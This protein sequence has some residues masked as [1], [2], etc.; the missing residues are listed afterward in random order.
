MS[1]RTQRP[2]LE[3][4]SDSF[5]DV[6]CNI[7][8]ILIILIV[9]VGVRLQRQPLAREAAAP[10]QQQQQLAEEAMR[11]SEHDEAVQRSRATRQELVQQQGHLNSDEKRLTTD[12]EAALQQNGMLDQQLAE[13]RGRIDAQ[14][15]ELAGKNRRTRKLEGERNAAAAR[16]ASLK[17]AIGKNGKQVSELETALRRASEAE[18]AT[19]G[20]IRTAVVETQKLGDVLEAAVQK[21]Q[22]ADRL[23]HRLSPV[24]RPVEADEHH[25][26]IDRG[27]VSEIPL[28][29]LLQ[30]LK[31]QVMARQ[32]TIMRFN[33]FEGSVGPVGGYSMK[34]TVE[35]DGPSALE[36]LQTG[37]GRVRVNVSRWEMIAEET[38]LQESTEEAVRPGSRFRQQLETYPPDSVITIW[39]YENSFAGFPAIRELAH[40]LQLRIAARPLPDGTPIIGSPN[41]SKSTAQ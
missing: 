35:K 5:L 28:D 17:S 14:K 7:V 31:A 9:V 39:I 15:L 24:T 8:G 33:Q 23:Q 36:S 30:R 32:S 34:Y 20:K 19:T 16:V 4:G 29:D 3:F 13:A 2:E 26:R 10:Q 1:R 27:Y 37:D 40:G 41:G 21:S 6:V 12:V 18:A 38:L 22:P 11:S 25:F